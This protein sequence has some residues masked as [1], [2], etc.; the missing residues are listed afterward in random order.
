MAGVPCKAGLDQ[1]WLLM[2]YVRAV[3][4]AALKVAAFALPAQAFT[5]TWVWSMTANTCV[6]SSKSINNARYV[7]GSYVTHRGKSTAPIILYCPM[8]SVADFEPGTSWYLD[9]TYL[10][11][12]GSGGGAVVEVKVVKQN[13]QS[14]VTSDVWTFN[15]N[16][17]NT[18]S[19]HRSSVTFLHDF[20]FETHAY[21]MQIKLDRSSKAQ[22]V[23]AYSVAVVTAP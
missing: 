12:N 19:I 11:S 8:S 14:G 16:D 4:F 3:F 5:A 10:D 21:Y 13:V 23:R 15:S 1:G 2:R 17:E 20:D 18:T 7:A 6:P 22:T 9:V